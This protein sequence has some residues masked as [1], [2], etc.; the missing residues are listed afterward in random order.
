MISGNSRKTNIPVQS[1]LQIGSV[2][3]VLLLV[4]G[5]LRQQ[6]TD[7]WDID[8][9][10]LSETTESETENETED[11]LDDFVY[12]LFSYEFR[13][14][15]KNYKMAGRPSYSHRLFKD[16]ITPPPETV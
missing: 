10:E 15:V 6:L 16:I 2:L 3:L 14:Q 1:W 4:F 7:I 5:E 13:L 8:S 11:E 9:I 12:E